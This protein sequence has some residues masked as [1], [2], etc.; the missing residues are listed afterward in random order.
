M[1]P[2]DKSFALFVLII[3]LSIGSCSMMTSVGHGI[4]EHG[5]CLFNCGQ[6]S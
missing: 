4:K 2:D 5:P 3:A 1:S 6:P